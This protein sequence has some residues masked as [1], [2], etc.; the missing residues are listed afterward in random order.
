LAVA[1]TVTQTGARTLRFW[2]RTRPGDTGE[3]IGERDGEQVVVQ[4]LPGGF[5]R[6][7]EAVARQL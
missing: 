5:A 2:L 4:P 3:L 7:L 6:R 1:S